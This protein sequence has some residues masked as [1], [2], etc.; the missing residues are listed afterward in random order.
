MRSTS[1]VHLR[2][3]L[4]FLSL[5]GRVFRKANQASFPSMFDADASIQLL[6]GFNPMS[7]L[8]QLP[9]ICPGGDLAVLGSIRVAH[10]GCGLQECVILIHRK[11]YNL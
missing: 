8:L 5:D 10:E 4:N 7:S 11:T 6:L 3:I 2:A 1:Y 9:Y